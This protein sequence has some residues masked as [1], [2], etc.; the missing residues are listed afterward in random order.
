MAV[1]IPQNVGGGN[2]SQNVGGDFLDTILAIAAPLFVVIIPLLS[3]STIFLG[4][5][6]IKFITLIGLSCLSLFFLFR[7]ASIKGASFT[8]WT[9][10]LKEWALLALIAH[11]LYFS[12]LHDF[13]TK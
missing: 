10:D 6:S 9:F 5:N 2:I 12:F 3:L 11:A 13:V 8:H 4:V 7:S 1:N